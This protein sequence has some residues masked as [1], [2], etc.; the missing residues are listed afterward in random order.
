ML[1]LLTQHLTA[2]YSG[3]NVFSYLTLRAI[4]ACMTSLVFCLLIGPSM[5]ARLSQYQ[6][7]QVV[8]DDG[9]K[10]HLP[11]EIGRAHV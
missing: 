11:K 2:L 5:I 4:L 6:I 1:Y 10:S 8:R 9:P 3:F 7:G